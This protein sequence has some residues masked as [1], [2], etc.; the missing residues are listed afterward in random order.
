MA[1]LY[2]HWAKIG[3]PLALCVFWFLIRA[4]GTM[5]KVVFLIWLQFPVYLIHEFEEHSWPGGFKKFI[6]REIFGITGR[7]FP[8]ND[9]NIFWINIPAIWILFPLG[10]L[11]AQKV[12]PSIGVLLPVFGLFNA[13]IHIVTTLLKRKY[14]PGFAAS[15]L[16]N[17]PTGFYTLAVM[18]HLQ[19]LT[20]A[21]SVGAIIFSLLVH[22][23]IAFYA[24]KKY[25]R[26][27]TTPDL[28]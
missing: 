10:A 27:T 8:L 7:D 14:N 2:K 22:A 23:G 12:N 20:T 28:K 3:L 21:A 25:R 16:L 5:P 6:N 11:L 24:Q 9:A 17:Y 4:A 15:L 19:L 13:T 18:H 26:D 1:F